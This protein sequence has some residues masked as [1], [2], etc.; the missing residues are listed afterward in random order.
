MNYRIGTTSPSSLQLH[1]LKEAQ[2]SS[3]PFEKA[4]A[5]MSVITDADLTSGQEE[6]HPD[7]IEVYSAI[8]GKLTGTPFENE[9]AKGFEHILQAEEAISLI[10]PASLDLAFLLGA[11]ASK[12]MP[13]GIPTVAELLPD[14]LE[15]GRRLDRE[16]VNR[17]ADF[18]ESSRITNIEDLLTAAQL[19]EY[20]GRN[21]TV[22]RL[23]EFL[24]YREGEEPRTRK[25]GPRS[26]VDIGSVAFLQDTLQVLFG[27]LS[28]RMLPAK[29]NP[30]HTA[31]A[32]YLQSRADSTVIT[33][34]YD[35]CIDLALGRDGKDFDY[36]MTFANSKNGGGDNLSNLI[37]LHGS[38]NWFYCDSC[39]KVNL[40]DIS[41]AI[42]DFEADSSPY[43]VIGV[44]KGCGGQR[45]GL[46]V[47]PLAMKFDLA[48]ALNP[49]LELANERLTKASVL[50]VVGFS[51]AE[52]DQY[53]SRMVSKWMQGNDQNRL[54]IFDPNHGVAEKMRKQ[55]SV[56][57]PNFD[58]N[59]VTWIG[60]DSAESVPK[61]LNREF[62]KARPPRPKPLVKQ[63]ARRKS[64]R[65]NMPE[66]DIA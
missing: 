6:L 41:K 5:L 38:L 31:I 34:N 61:F 48:P 7:W 63:P 55:C 43:P 13:S 18:C 9:L 46:L 30:V 28:S 51:F 39:Q 29:P 4:R 1:H 44:C 22:L 26:R 16:D 24:L 42:K 53:I 62:V 49:L 32:H 56:R 20:C 65:P 14:L 10:D 64:K 66:A 17:L 23:I 37:K 58:R 35:C 15:R 59:R 3:H 19:A 27:L 45:R 40:I 47:P 8:R 57:I 60:G 52:A 33:T 2:S 54:V 50:V 25:F 36:R 21:P 12:P 11:G